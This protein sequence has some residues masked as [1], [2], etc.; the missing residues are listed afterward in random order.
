[1][2]YY[3]FGVPSNLK[4][5]ELYTTDFHKLQSCVNSWKGYKDFGIMIIFREY[6]LPKFTKEAQHQSQD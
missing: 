4:M 3:K 5:D 6:M 2:L 1:M